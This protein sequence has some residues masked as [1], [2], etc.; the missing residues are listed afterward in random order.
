MKKS[1]ETALLFGDLKSPWVLWNCGSW[2]EELEVKVEGVQAWSSWY[3]L[4]FTDF[5]LES[6]PWK[7]LESFMRSHTLSWLRTWS[8]RTRR[9]CERL[10]H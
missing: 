3:P 5:E 7:E 8:W 6:D 4:S 1:L 2:E 9:S 10:R